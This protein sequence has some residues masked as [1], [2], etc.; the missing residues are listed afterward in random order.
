M[1]CPLRKITLQT[2]ASSNRDENIHASHSATEG[3][4]KPKTEDRRLQSIKWNVLKRFFQRQN[5]EIDQV[6]VL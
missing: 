2:T 6:F 5:N 3:V 1:V 4:S